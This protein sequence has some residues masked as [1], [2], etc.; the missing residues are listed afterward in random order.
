M[1]TQYKKS[2][3]T[4]N[5]LINAVIDVVNPATEQVIG[6]RPIAAGGFDR[7]ASAGSAPHSRHGKDQCC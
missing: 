1:T 6:L 3:S 7:E 4:A 5:W 2:G